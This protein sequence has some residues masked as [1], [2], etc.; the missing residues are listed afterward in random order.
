MINDQ[1]RNDSLEGLLMELAD[2]IAKRFECS[3]PCMVTKVSADR[4]RVS[5]RP[6]IRIVGQDGS[7][8]ARDVID[9]VTVYQSGAGDLVM[10]FPVAVGD[11]GW[12]EATDRDLGLFLQS[13]GES[14]PPSRRKHSFSDGVFVPDVMTNF[15]IAGEDSTA[16][17]IQNRAG[18]VKIALDENEI[19]VKN[20]GTTWAITDQ[21]ITAEAA[22]NIGMTAGGNINMTAGGSMTMVAPG[23]I[24]LNGAVVSSGGEIK[25]SS[26]VSLSNHYHEQPNDSD[27]SVEQPTSP[28]VAT[29]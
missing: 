15:T 7:T 23:G 16:V 25:T 20:Q 14:D 29:E 5:V 22:G 18:T 12:I 27:G 21:D 1:S 28:A 10:S 11:I 17:V 6:L 9:G 13:Y 8:L 19:R 4:T 26:G 3:L 2:S 24:N